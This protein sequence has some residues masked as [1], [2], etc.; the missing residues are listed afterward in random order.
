MRDRGNQGPGRGAAK[1]GLSPMI[2]KNP[3]SIRGD[4][5]C[6]PHYCSTT[7]DFQTFLR[8]HYVMYLPNTGMGI[9]YRDSGKSKIG[10]EILIFI[11]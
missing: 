6:P 8:E 7:S 9:M 11:Q 3:I 10:G 4:R 2:F 1:S 5:V